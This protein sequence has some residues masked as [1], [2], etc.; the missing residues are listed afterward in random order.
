MLMTKFYHIKKK[1]CL[2]HNVRGE[3]SGAISVN[4]TIPSRLRGLLYLFMI[5]Q[6]YDNLTIQNR[7]VYIV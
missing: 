6:F 7:R 2:Y 1:I 5:N 3:T 4:L